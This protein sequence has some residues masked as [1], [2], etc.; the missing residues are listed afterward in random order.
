MARKPV[1]TVRMQHTEETLTSLARM[2]YA[3]FCGANRAARTV[4]SLAL[5]LLGIRY[6]DQWWGMLVI[7]YGGYLLV[8]ARQAAT[9]PA[10]KMIEQMKNGGVKLP[11]STYS[12]YRAG[13]A[14][15]PLDP[16]HPAEAP[17]YDV[18][19]GEDYGSRIRGV[20]LG[21]NDQFLPYSKVY[22][23][24]EDGKYFYIFRDQ[25]GGFVV[26][27]EA[28]GSRDREF[29]DFIEQHCDQ[30]FRSGSSPLLRVMAAS[31]LWNMRK[32]RL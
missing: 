5:L 16:E 6:M 4:I 28:L 18:D 14:V 19:E 11:A 17:I 24:G 27:R 20:P 10:R 2:Q 26:P 30:T 1:F 32:K 23:L 3:L 25:Y 29:R 9:R 8:S 13:M 15:T 31:R 21:E 12:F 7:A 22:R